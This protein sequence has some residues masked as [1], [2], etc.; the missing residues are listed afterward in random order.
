M[1]IRTD[2]SEWGFIPTVVTDVAL[3]L[4]ILLGLSLWRRNGGGKFGLARLLYRQVGW[5]FS[6]AFLRLI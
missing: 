3:L 6:L 2:P 1:P 4:L 5:R